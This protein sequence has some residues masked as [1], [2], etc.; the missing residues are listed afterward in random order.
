MRAE[1]QR[2][3]QQAGAAVSAAKRHIV[4]MADQAEAAEAAVE[5]LRRDLVTAAAREAEA[6]E[7]TR[8]SVRSALVL[9]ILCCQRRRVGQALACALW[10]WR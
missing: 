10:G 3:L 5:K 8:V 6:R 9:H 4:E 7:E 1:S 2:D